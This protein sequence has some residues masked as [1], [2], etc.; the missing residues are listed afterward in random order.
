MF[1]KGP[2]NQNNVKKI[3]LNVQNIKILQKYSLIPKDQKKY[4]IGTMDDV[5]GDFLGPQHGTTPVA[6][7]ANKKNNC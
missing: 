5:R 1:H 7:I 3:I 4:I 2:N 6:V